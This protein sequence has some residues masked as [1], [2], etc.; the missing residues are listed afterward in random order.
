MPLHNSSS[1][2]LHTAHTLSCSPKL[3]N[4]LALHF[5]SVILPPFFSDGSLAAAAAIKT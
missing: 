5:L 1:M 3:Q 4:A 2:F